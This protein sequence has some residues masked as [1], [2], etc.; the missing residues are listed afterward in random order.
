VGRW[1]TITTEGC[2]AYMRGNGSFR[3]G[4]SR[5]LTNRYGDMHDTEFTVQ[6]GRLYML[7]TRSAKRP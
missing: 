5:R 6:D 3:T 7:Q 4:S 1:F 2:V